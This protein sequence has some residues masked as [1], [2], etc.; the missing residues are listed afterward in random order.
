MS[1]SNDKASPTERGE[2][3]PSVSADP[4]DAPQLDGK[5]EQVA[6]DPEKVEEHEKKDASDS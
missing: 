5:K 1:T 4:A 3:K 2:E 6:P